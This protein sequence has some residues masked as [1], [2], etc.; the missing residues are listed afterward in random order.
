MDRPPISSLIVIFLTVFGELHKL[1]I[2][3]IPSSYDTVSTKNW[4][5]MCLSGFGL[6]LVIYCLFASAMS[7]CELFARQI[8]KKSPYE[9]QMTNEY[10]LCGLPYKAGAISC[11]WHIASVPHCSR[12]ITQGGLQESAVATV[13]FQI[14]A[15]TRK[16]KLDK[17][18]HDWKYVICYL[19]TLSPL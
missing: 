4:K 11:V 14:Y 18:I 8:G 19:T 12:C 13:L 2:Y 17:R 6:I 9:R 16:L 15:N 7:F 1:R 10:L 5:H 3:F